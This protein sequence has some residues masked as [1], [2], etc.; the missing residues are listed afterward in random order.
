[1]AINFNR[2]IREYLDTVK[3]DIESELTNQ[4]PG[5]SGQA[6]SSLRVVANQFLI[7]ELRGVVYLNFLLKGF[8]TKP[9]SVSRAFIDNIISWMG[10]RNIQP[11]RDG[12]I[13]PSSET[14]IRRSAFAI[15]KGVVDKGTPV[16]RSEKGIDLQR[17]L[18]ENL[19]EY[20]EGVAGNLLVNFQD[21]IK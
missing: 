21:K 12:E 18:N 17:I 19:P 15:A 16:T 2:Q 10:F 3:L 5:A 8:T 11:M 9:R 7:G 6:R 13:L 20:L 4:Y 1:M 14:N